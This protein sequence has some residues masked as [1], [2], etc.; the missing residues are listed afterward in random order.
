MFD[1][2]VVRCLMAAVRTAAISLTLLVAVSAE[3]QGQTVLPLTTTG[4]GT[5]TLETN[6]MISVTPEPSTLVLLA[7]G[8]AGLL[9]YGLRR[10]SV[11]KRTAKPAA[12][13][14]VEP[15][16]DGPAILSL[17]SRWTEATRRAA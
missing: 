12:I 14:Q 4:A 10:Q 6:G 17:P 13:D 15:Q 5:V 1:K 8:A 3:T 16:D 11:A 9:G 2:M 7:A